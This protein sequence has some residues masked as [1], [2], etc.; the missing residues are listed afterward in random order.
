MHVAAW[1]LLRIPSMET[2]TIVKE[3]PAILIYLT[4]CSPALTCSLL[5]WIIPTQRHAYSSWCDLCFLSSLYT[6]RQTNLIT[7]FG[8]PC[9]WERYL[10]NKM[11]TPT[12]ILPR[13]SWRCES[14]PGVPF[15]TS[16]R[17]NSLHLSRIMQ[18]P[19]TR[20]AKWA[21][22][23]FQSASCKNT[24]IMQSIVPGSLCW[25]QLLKYI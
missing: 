18:S 6:D 7:R 5:F 20:L 21:G 8:T 22:K 10:I 16:S 25:L 13:T 9:L 15:A 3:S 11:Y 4:H 17:Q 23:F 19:C 24:C 2:M 1:L 12:G 14:Y